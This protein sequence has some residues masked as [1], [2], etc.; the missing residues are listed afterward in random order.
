[1]GVSILVTPSALVVIKAYHYYN[2][3]K[4]DLDLRHVGYNRSRSIILNW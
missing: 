3:Y 1:M 2:C 4:I